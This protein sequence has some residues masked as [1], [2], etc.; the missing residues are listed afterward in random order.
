MEMKKETGV[1]LAVAGLLGWSAYG[2]ISDGA[3]DLRG[4]ASGAAKSYSQAAVPDSGLAL[5]TASRSGTLQRDL[6]SPPRDT[7]PLPLLEL[8][9]PPL[10]PLPALAPP[11]RV[12]PR[13][14]AHGQAPS[15]P[16]P[17]PIGPGPVQCIVHGACAHQQR[18]LGRGYDGERSVGRRPHRRRAP[19]PH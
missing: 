13:R 17:D 14:Q 7:T 16:D 6:F 15:H 10:E 18:R 4:G 19:R 12:R 3:V 1:F 5:P 8:I 2:L 9:L 11:Q